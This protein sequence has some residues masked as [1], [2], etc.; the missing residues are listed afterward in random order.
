MSVSLA[1]ARRLIPQVWPSLL[2]VVV[3]ALIG[4]LLLVRHEVPL[5]S[6]PFPDSQE[7]VTSAD[8]LAHGRGYTTPVRDTASTA[9]W[10]N[11]ENPPR[12]SPGYSLA[13]VPFALA[14]HFPRNVE[15]G[16][17]LTVVL[18]VVAVAWAAL[19]LGGPWAAILAMA[20]LGAGSFMKESALYVLSDAFAAALAVAVLA[21]VKRLTPLAVY[22]GGFLAGYGLLVRASGLVILASLLIV[23]RG[24]DRLRALVTAAPPVVGLLAY[25]WV[26][27]GRPWRTGYG[28]WLPHLKMF[29]LSFVTQH[30]LQGDHIF[31][32]QLNHRAEKWLCHV[33]V[34]CHG[35]SPAGALPNWL[36]YIM[37]L[38]GGLW[39]FAPPLVSLVGMVVAFRWWR[40]PAAQFTLFVTALTG[41]LYL[42][43]FFQAA[44]FMAAPALML[45]VLACAG[46]IRWLQASALWRD[47]RI[48]LMGANAKATVDSTPRLSNRV[49]RASGK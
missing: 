44:R 14:G 46:A 29:S 18:M 36:F 25:Q 11:A 30:P 48:A 32:D 5:R 4:T 40:E 19:E 16:A 49:A 26:T 35:A 24:R 33:V 42:P 38:G 13:L 27:F 8:Q 1:D 10:A 17:K 20:L 22:L 43:Y 7:Y 45:I 12:S 2:L 37:V 39:I 6:Q 15:F 41:A 47:V 34:S 9:R 23:L 28:Y 31:T 3:L 21:L